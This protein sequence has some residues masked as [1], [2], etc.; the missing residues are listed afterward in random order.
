MH[1]GRITG[2][3]MSVLHFTVFHTIKATFCVVRVSSILSYTGGLKH[4]VAKMIIMV[5]V[6]V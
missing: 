4:E 5:I 6:N 1:I 2:A 3:V